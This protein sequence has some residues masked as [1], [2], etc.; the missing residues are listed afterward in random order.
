MYLR[1]LVDGVGER[2]PKTLKLDFLKSFAVLDLPD[3]KR[4]LECY[5]LGAT[6]VAP[7]L[8][9]RR[10]SGNPGGDALWLQSVVRWVLSLYEDGYWY[11]QVREH[12]RKSGLYICY[13]IPLSCVSSFAFWARRCHPQSW[14]PI[15][16]SKRDG[17]G[18]GVLSYLA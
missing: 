2:L 16:V 3:G 13:S 8:V 7:T 15:R 1:S 12:G 18:C 4:E 5:Q 17:C 10:A 11:P 9:G 14:R 6:E